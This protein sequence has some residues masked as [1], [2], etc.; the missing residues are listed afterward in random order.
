MDRG[1]FGLLALFLLAT[2]FCHLRILWA[3]ECYP[4]AGAIQ[5]LHGKTLYRDFWY[6]K[7]PLTPLVYLLW[8]GWPGWP[9]RLAGTVFAVAVCWVAY[10][11]AA[12]LWG[13]R[14]GI[15][16]ACG[17]A[18]FLTF[19][20]A[21][22][23]TTIAP[24]LL[25]VLPHL[26]AV[27]CAWRGRALAA[28]VLAGLCFQVNPKGLVIAAVCLLWAWRSWWRFAAG[29]VMSNA[30]VFFWAWPGRGRCRRTGGKCGSGDWFTRRTRLWNSQ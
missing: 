7:P 23:V 18:F 2:R 11:M 26:A 30:L 28:G 12:S 22:S 3:E 9:L 10:R 4:A 27:W 24:D 16:A 13:R 6:D 19:D 20:I 8:G 14:E 29:Y 1:W 25:M 21:S 17:M 5:L 15:A